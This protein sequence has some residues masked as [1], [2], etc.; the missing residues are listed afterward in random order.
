[1]NRNIALGLLS[2]LLVS[3]TP[4]INKLVLNSFDPYTASSI[5]FIFCTL[6]SICWG[7]V[8]KR[9]K[10]PPANK[11][12]ILSS[13]FYTCGIICLFKSLESSSPETFGI[14]SRS[15]LLWAAFFSYIF[16]Q[17]SFGTSKIIGL[18][19]ILIGT[20]LFFQRDF[21]V[22]K[23]VVWGL[24]YGIFFAANNIFTK[25]T[26]KEYQG[27]TI[28][29]YNNLIPSILG[30]LYLLNDFF[31]HNAIF[32]IYPMAYLG[33][34]TFLGSFFGII[35]FYKSLDK[36]E[37]T[38]AVLIR[39]LSPIVVGFYSYLFFPISYSWINLM[40]ASLTILGL[41]VFNVKIKPS[42]S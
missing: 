12:M 42:V 38:F 1:M 35:L 10:L 30:S 33:I 11:N 40:G 7:I 17:E 23:G 31:N 32:P 15:Q 26:T 29:L 19:L 36:L 41:V 39:A 4:I 34:S 16:F 8:F 37:F 21:F 3:T 22:L 20:I 6:F 28:V 9:S 25:K 18:F 5:S 24:L 13:F 27:W 14:I 2:V